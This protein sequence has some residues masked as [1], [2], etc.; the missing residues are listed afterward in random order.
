VIPA[1]V[2]KALTDALGD[3]IALDVS[4]SQHI[5]LRVGGP[6]DAFAR[7]AS[8]DDLSRLLSLCSEAAL[9][10]T[11][12]GSGFNTLVTDGGVE[13]VVISLKKLRAIDA[14]GEDAVS[15]EAGVSHSQVTRF[16]IDRGLTGLEFGAG[17][18]GTVGGWVAMNAGIGSREIA[19]VVQSIEVMRIDGR[20][21]FR[22]DRADLDFS[23]R[24]LRGLPMGTV[25][26]QRALASERR[27]RRRSRAR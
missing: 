12:L 20:D 23:Y 13:G 8:R 22:I 7:P 2:Q 15:A 6:A 11:L 9:P 3:Q 26:S 4:M 14:E 21:T 17:V 10:I 25:L 27:S 5:A 19:D 16:C 18:P 24:A 1:E